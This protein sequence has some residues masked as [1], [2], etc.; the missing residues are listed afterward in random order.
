MKV[1]LSIKFQCFCLRLSVCCVLGLASI[2]F[3]QSTEA[4]FFLRHAT[5]VSILELLKYGISLWG[6]G[7]VQVGSRPLAWFV[8][9]VAMVCLTGVC[10]FFCHPSCV[11]QYT[12]LVVYVP[13]RYGHS[14]SASKL[15]EHYWKRSSLPV[16][17]DQRGQAHAIFSCSCPPCQDIDYFV[18]IIVVLIE[19]SRTHW[20]HLSAKKLSLR[21]FK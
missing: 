6:M 1:V 15:L 7:R 8:S 21:C 16:G 2:W 18:N 13:S 4:L 9:I 5:I 14:D 20:Y 10:Y 11:V 17:F 3:V 19:P 12:Q